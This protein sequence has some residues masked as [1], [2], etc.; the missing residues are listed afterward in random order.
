MADF[1]P[2]EKRR[3]FFHHAFAAGTEGWVEFRYR[4]M[5]T[6]SKSLETTVIGPGEL[7]LPISNPARTV[8]EP[9]DYY[10]DHIRNFPDCVKTRQEPLEPVEVGHRT[11]S[12]CHL[13]NIAIQ[14]VNKKLSWDPDQER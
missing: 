6:S 2:R 3:A 14:R 7:Q 8:A 11:A 12:L 10:A 13:W 9:G 4:S 1:L 5:R